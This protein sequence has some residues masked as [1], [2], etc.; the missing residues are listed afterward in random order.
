[1]EFVETHC[2]FDDDAFANDL[3]QVIDAARAAG[4]R[5]FINIGYEPESWIRSLELA[6]QIPDISYALGMH[7]NWAD[8][9]SSETAAELEGLLRSSDAV[10]IGE[11]GLD[12]YRE[13][14]D[15]SSQRAAFRDQLE[16][17][18]TFSL[19]VVIHMRGDVEDEI[20]AALSDFADVRCVFHSF[21]GSAT[22]RD[23]ALRRGDF[24]GVG[25]LMTRASQGP[26]REIL[27]KVPLDSVVLETDS[28]Y[29]TPK[30]IKDR[31][32]TP[33]SLPLIAEALSELHQVSVDRVAEQTTYNAIE[34]FSFC[35][36]AIIGAA[37]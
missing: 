11:T 28:P 8:R 21:D 34:L 2:H 3:P 10:A 13:W 31:R 23:F 15:Q 19:P 29:L 18:R 27:R 4:V 6:A 36:S 7:P 37:R 12:Y 5:R 32:N 33:A 14:V 16:L 9:W 1:M 30:G 24:I 26:L 22:L 17:A 25:G 20:V 35:S